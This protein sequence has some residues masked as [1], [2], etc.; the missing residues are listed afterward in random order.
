MLSIN[1][2]LPY[3]KS[4]P[5]VISLAN[6]TSFQFSM[7][8][9]L[10]PLISQFLHIE[11]LLKVNNSLTLPCQSALQ[12]P[13]TMQIKNPTALT[14]PHT[15]IRTTVQPKK[16]NA[17]SLKYQHPAIPKPLQIKKLPKKEFN[18]AK[19]S[20]WPRRIGL[21]APQSCTIYVWLLVNFAVRDDL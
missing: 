1:Q 17:F 19:L 18:L 12:N 11:S 20:G 21:R 9:P 14:T 6:S 13:T 5:I 8:A 16:N 2:D 10:K 4:P 15:P 3:K 7:E